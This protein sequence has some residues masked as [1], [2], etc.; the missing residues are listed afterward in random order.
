LL[1]FQGR[2]TTEGAPV[3]EIRGATRKALQNLVEL[4][5]REQVDFMVVAGDIYDGDLA[6]R[7]LEATG[8]VRINR[9]FVGI[10]DSS[11]RPQDNKIGRHPR[12]E[13][14]QTLVEAQRPGGVPSGHGE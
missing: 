4:A 14:A 9:G 3:E 2:T 5:I 11:S 6:D 8:T 7:L 12:G 10:G 1:R 13:G